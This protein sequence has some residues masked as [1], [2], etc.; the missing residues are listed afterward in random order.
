MFPG[1]LKRIYECYT[2]E[3]YASRLMNLSRNALMHSG[4]YSACM[5]ITL[6]AWSLTRRGVM[7]GPVTVT[8][9][10]TGVYSYWKYV[11]KFDRRE[12]QRYLQ[13][14]ALLFSHPC[15]RN[16][17]VYMCNCTV[18]RSPRESGTFS[19]PDSDLRLCPNCRCS[20]TSSCGGGRLPVTLACLL[21]Y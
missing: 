4:A 10:M 12:T 13:V 1:G 3:I 18:N 6:H 20:T 19:A 14:S 9:P 5:G 16:V 17:C 8:V 15:T 7:H 11:S 2:W 21:A